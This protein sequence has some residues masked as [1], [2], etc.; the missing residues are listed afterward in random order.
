MAQWIVFGVGTALALFGALGV[1]LVRNPVH[2]AL[3]LVQTL[4]GVAILFVN[5]GAHFL[6]VVQVIVYAGAVVV[7]FL[8][9][10][11]LLGVDRNEDV[12]DEPL[13]GQRPLALLVGGL[14]IV[15]LVALFVLRSDSFQTGQPGTPGTDSNV[16]ELSKAVFTR[17]LYPFEIT[18]VLLVIA[19]VGAVLLARRPKGLL[20]TG[21][22]PEVAAVDGGQ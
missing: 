6:A 17:Y 22:R 2:A 16:K 7:L 19:V 21:E 9:V 14:G 4:F 1:V 13:R 5:Q 12:M 20:T 8:F 11:M 15:E 18:S 3:L 10:I